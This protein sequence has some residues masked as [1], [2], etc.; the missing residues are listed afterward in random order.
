MEDPICLI[1]SASRT[2]QREEVARNLNHALLDLKQEVN[3]HVFNPTH[4]Q[5]PVVLST[6]ACG[7]LRV[8]LEGNHQPK[9]ENDP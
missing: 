7:D 3:V 8:G 2:Q 6:A 1:V 9:A 5:R 4:V